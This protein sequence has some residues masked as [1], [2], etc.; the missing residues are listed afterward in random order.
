M[1]IKNEILISEIG[2]SKLRLKCDIMT[3]VQAGPIEQA[4]KALTK[5]HIET[6]F[7]SAKKEAIERLIK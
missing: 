6:I 2:V 4:K 3:T 7:E 5:E 1:L